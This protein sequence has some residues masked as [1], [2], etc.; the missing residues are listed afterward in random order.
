MAKQKIDP[1]TK[2]IWNHMNYERKFESTGMW[3]CG[4]EIFCG[5]TGKEVTQA[6]MQTMCEKHMVMT[7]KKIRAA[8]MAESE[9]TLKVS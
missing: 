7:V 2:L 8:L 6:Q 5:P 4:E 9:T 3:M 1:V